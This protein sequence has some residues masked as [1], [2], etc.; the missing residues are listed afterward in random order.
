MMKLTNQTLAQLDKKVICPEFDRETT[1]VG[2]VH[3]GP[4]A[5]SRSHQAW[6]TQQALNLKG[7][8]WGI[9]AVDLYSNHVKKMLEP[10]QGLYTLV[11]LDKTAQTS[12]IGSIKEVL[13]YKE[14]FDKAIARLCASTTKIV[15][16]TV[17]EK[18]YYLNAD[19]ELDKDNTVIQE[20]FL[21]PSTPKSTVGLLVLICQM[22]QEQ[23]IAPLSIISCDNVSDNG[24]KLKRALLAYAEHINPELAQFID[25]KIVCPCTM[26]DS[27][28]PATTEELG[29]DIEKNFHYQDNWPIKREAFTQWV[30]EDILPNDIPAWREVGAVFT[31]DVEGYEM[32][33]LRVLNATHSALAYIG[34]LLEIETVCDAIHK[35]PILVFIEKMLATEIKPSF[36]IPQG[37]DFEQY[38]QSIIQR[39]RNPEIRHLLAQIAWDGSQKLPMRILPVISTNLQNNQP[40]EKCCFTVAAWMRF[41]VKRSKGD[42]EL[43]DPLKDALLNI[44]SQCNDDAQH[45]LNLFLSLDMFSPLKSDEQFLQAVTNSYTVLCENNQDSLLNLL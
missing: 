5:F 7:G 43:I 41:I 17:T 29:K 36:D 30:I 12:I 11:E 20:D 37:M 23:G 14:D 42:I 24:K 19:G 10:Q 39:Y 1:E 31:K 15:T 2:I 45:D 28:T 22:R 9:C 18:G 34:C 40:I 27:I 6:F 16:I 21:T 32:A 8:N 26:V 44:G 33:K 13:C 3:L 4:G 38:C 25:E 35:A